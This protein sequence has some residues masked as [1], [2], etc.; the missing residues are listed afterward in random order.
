MSELVKCP[1]CGSEQIT[2]NK[3]G[4]NA[5]KAAAGFFLAGGVG[6]LAGQLGANKVRVSCLACG[7][8][9][10]AG[11]PGMTQEQLQKPITPAGWAGIIFFIVG[12][13][14]VVYLFAQQW[15]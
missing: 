4:I 7:H 1:R 13:A 10:E 11:K 12:M 6:L 14:I 9:W 5:G 8:D 3:Q 2:S 15:K